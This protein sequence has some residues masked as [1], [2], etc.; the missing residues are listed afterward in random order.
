MPLLLTEREIQQVIEQAKMIF[1]NL[2]DW[3]YQNDK[4]EDYFGFSLWGQLVLN[5]EDDLPQ[6]FFITFD[7]YQENWY[8]HL[9]I[10]QPCYFWTSA[11]VGDAHL[12]NTKPCQTLAEAMAALKAEMVRLFSALTG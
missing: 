7:T 11:D 4:N 1:P 8:G 10:G 6:R 3:E 2:T 5:P 12:L 9:T